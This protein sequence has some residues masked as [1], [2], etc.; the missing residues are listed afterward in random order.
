MSVLWILGEAKSGKSELAESIFERLP[1]G[2]FYIGTLPRTPRWMDT[3]RKHAERRPKD[4]RLIEI[5]DK[6]DVATEVIA[7]EGGEEPAVLLDGWGVYARCRATQWS[8]NTPIAAD[9]TRFVEEIYG[10]YC[11]LVDVCGYLV[12]V[13]HVSAHPPE[14]SDYEA[15]P[16]AFLVRAATSHCIADA[17]KVIYHDIED[18][19]HEDES[20]VRKIAEELI[21]SRLR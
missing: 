14:P 2:K 20:Y 6:L 18:V 15:D 3:I 7:R 1:G 21:F 12:L 19:T 16:I 10:E 11:R 5:T 13:A 4:W 9:E 17:D 8:G